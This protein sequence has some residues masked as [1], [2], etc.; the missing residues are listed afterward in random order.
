MLQALETTDDLAKLLAL[1]EVLHGAFE[2]FCGYTQQFCGE[3][4][5][6]DIETAGESVPGSVDLAEHGAGSNVYP[7][8]L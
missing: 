6:G 8:Q 3:P 7:V 1:L 5:V 4:D 2:G